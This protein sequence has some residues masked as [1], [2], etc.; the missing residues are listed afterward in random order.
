MVIIDDG[1]DTKVVSPAPETSEVL[2]A[3]VTMSN[4]I[5]AQI[6]ANNQPPPAYYEA[7]A[8]YNTPLLHP[9]N[10]PAERLRFPPRENA[11]RRFLR[12]FLVATFVLF[13]LAFLTESFVVAVRGVQWW[14]RKVSSSFS[15]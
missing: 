7:T 1:P 12:A 3:P 14:G 4:F 15:L 9:Y 2:P 10:L 5:H 6:L 8:N 13:L 11:R